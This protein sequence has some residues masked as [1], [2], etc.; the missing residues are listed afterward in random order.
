MKGLACKG[1]QQFHL[2]VFITVLT[3]CHVPDYA[4]P[5]NSILKHLRSCREATATVD[6]KGSHSGGGG[7][8][9]F[10]CHQVPFLGFC[11]DSLSFQIYWEDVPL[12]AFQ[13]FP[14]KSRG[15]TKTAHASLAHFEKYKKY[16]KN[17]PRRSVEAVT[18]AWEDC[19]LFEW[20]NGSARIWSTVLEILKRSYL[21]QSLKAFFF[22]D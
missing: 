19:D 14:I 21:Q 7:C 13:A 17:L 8:N 5:L 18:L 15:L 3:K 16:S 22:L 12:I 4:F 2:P 9:L 11:P 10:S 6:A 1:K 20:H